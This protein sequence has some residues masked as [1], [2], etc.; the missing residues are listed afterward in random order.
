MIDALIEIYYSL[1]QHKLRTTLTAFG[2]FWGIFL[3][4]LLLGAGR[5]LQN[6]IEA[7]LSSNSIDSVWLWTRATSLP[8]KGLNTGRRAPLLQD[9]IDALRKDIPELNYVSS[10][11]SIGGGRNSSL[12]S[13]GNRS[14][15]FSVLGVG[16]D[17]FKIKRHQEYR[18]GRRLNDLDNKYARK[19]CTIGTLVAEQ[20]FADKN[21]IGEELTIG[22]VSFKVVGL[23]YDR[24]NQGQHSERI[25]IPFSIF[26]ALFSNGNP[27]VG[28]L[29]YESKPGVDRREVETKVIK[30]IKQRHRIHPDDKSAVRT[31]SVFK[32]NE[33]VERMFYTINIFIWFVGIGTLMAGIVGISNIMMITV[34]ERTVEIGV[35]KALGAQPINIVGSLVFESV[36]ITSIAGYVGLVFGVC[37]L[38]LLAFTL[39]ALSIE[40]EFFRKPEVDFNSA[41]YALI[42]LVSVGAL[43]GLIPAWHAA[44]IS[45]IEAMRD[46]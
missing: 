5:G 11:R 36:L 3:L 34:K 24:Q 28:W 22:G 30:L 4:I 2:V 45:P 29:A 13:Y 20:L 26:K 15:T 38:E 42:I 37:V 27:S 31:W 33:P 19:V 21:P 1:K 16:D 18:R 23:F 7:G 32:N 6:G 8:Y 12:V 25:Y 9:D 40:S 10:E 39:E 14:S 44:K 35:R 41:F 46:A 17:F 43:A